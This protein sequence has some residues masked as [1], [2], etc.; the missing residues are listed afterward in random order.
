[1]L[2]GI[3]SNEMNAFATVSPYSHITIDSYR[4]SPCGVVSRSPRVRDGS[5]R[6]LM[7]FILLNFSYFLLTSLFG[8]QQFAPV[9]NLD[10]GGK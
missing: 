5:I 6:K 9:S 7:Y 1:M 3:V 8:L 4:T 10:P 2:S